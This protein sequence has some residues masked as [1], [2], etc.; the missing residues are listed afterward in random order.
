MDKLRKRYS[1][2]VHVYITSSLMLLIFIHAAHIYVTRMPRA[3]MRM[4]V[5]AA[6]YVVSQTRLCIGCV[7]AESNA[8][9]DSNT[10]ESTRPCTSGIDYFGAEDGTS[11]ESS[12]GDPSR[13]S[14]AAT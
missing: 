14:C 8:S 10:G 6:G 12:T 4:H 7:G 5:V 1:L 11:C 13:P 9:V 2:L 3:G